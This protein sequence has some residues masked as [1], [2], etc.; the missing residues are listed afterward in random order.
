MKNIRKYNYM[1]LDNFYVTF[2][3]FTVTAKGGNKMRDFIKKGWF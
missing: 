3:N 1:N 2:M